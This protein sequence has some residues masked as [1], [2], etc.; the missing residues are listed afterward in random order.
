MQ[1]V[2]RFG[3]TYT[4]VKCKVDRKNEDFNKGYVKARDGSLIKVEVS[5]AKK[6]GVAYWVKLTKLKKRNYQQ[7][8]M[9]L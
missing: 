5:P 9:N 4:L 8:E 1:N 6:D 7:S 3:N 2:D